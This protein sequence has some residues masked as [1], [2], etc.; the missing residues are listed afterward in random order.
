MKTKCI[1]RIFGR[2]IIEQTKTEE[3]NTFMKLR[4]RLGMP[5]FS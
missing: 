2:K 4:K 3:N 1:L 5:N